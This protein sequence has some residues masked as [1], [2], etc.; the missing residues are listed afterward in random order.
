MRFTLL[1]LLLASTTGTVGC[2]GY[3][4]PPPKPPRSVPT[5]DLEPA[6]A[7]DGHGRIAIQAVGV[8]G[9]PGPFWVGVETSSSANVY[10]SASTHVCAATPCVANLPYGNWLLRIG[11]NKQLYGLVPVV[12]GARPTIVNVVVGCFRPG[13]F[14]SCFQDPSFVQWEPADG[15]VYQR[16]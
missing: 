2:S 4:P 5:V 11:N 12:V 10:L 14:S 15:V 3:R 1:V 13:F 16:P 8:H 9:E 6:P 7:V